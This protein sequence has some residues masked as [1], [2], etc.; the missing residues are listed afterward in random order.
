MEK[1]RKTLEL[2]AGESAPSAKDDHVVLGEHSYR[3]FS[4]QKLAVV[5][6]NFRNTNQIVMEIG[7]DVPARDRDPREDHIKIFSRDLRGG[8][9]RCQQKLVEWRG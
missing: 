4:K 7:H 2:G 9:R 3:G 1:E 8:H 6:T 5:V